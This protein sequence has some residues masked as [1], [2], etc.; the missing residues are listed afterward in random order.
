MIKRIISVFLACALTI[1]LL[2]ACNDDKGGAKGNGEGNSGVIFN[3]ELEK[4]VT[5]RVLE[6]DTAIQKGYFEELIKA[7]NEKYKD[8]GIVAVDANMDQYSD[9]ANDGPYGYGPDVLYQ[10]NDVLM[11]YVDGKHILPLPVEDLESY[12]AIPETAWNAYKA[13]VDGESYTMGV[14]VNVQAP[15]LYYR[16]DTLPENWEE[17]WDDDKN[18]V[19]DMIENWS[20]MYAYSKSIRESDPSKYG[21]MQSLYDV[22][23]SAGFL[24]SYGGYAFGK[25]N[26]DPEDIGWAAGEAEKGASVLLQ[27]A[28]LM[29]EESIDDS[30]T[31]NAYSKLGEG[32]YFA[33]L[34]TPD[35]Y[36]TFIQEMVLA[37]EAQ[38]MSK[39]EAKK[40][41]EE[42]LGI[43]NMP[44]LPKSGV[45][46]EENPELIPGKTMGGVNGYAIS[47]YTK[48]PN[49]ALAFVEFATSYEMIMKRN[50]I[51]GIVPARNDAA[52]EL[53][54]LSEVLYSTLEEGNIVLM[55]SIKE[56]AQM[57]TPGQTFFTDLAK[58]A[59]R[60]DGEKKFKDLPSLKA[61]LE[62][63]S[64]Q[65]YDAI[66]TLK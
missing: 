13:E 6:N 11:K 40:A 5:L 58:D 12:D 47:A 35:N 10:A 29:N 36:T 59:Y 49:A 62:E 9:L 23:F 15:I 63:M 19:P 37:Y 50:E 14:P 32:S 17:Q 54:G 3:G 8:Q 61:G 30:I 55:P 18:S 7:F 64:Q 42:N 31:V 56:V 52:E 16:K 22:Y 57:W 44:D 33:T 48:A 4:N 65:I 26:T 27:L 28:S 24:F 1:P 60:P 66:F 21:Y 51:L 2:A 53:G 25:N 20:D 43:V 34:S 38:G 46:S 41:A 39:E 45:L